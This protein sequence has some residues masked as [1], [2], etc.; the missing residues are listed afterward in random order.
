MHRVSPGGAPFHVLNRAVGQGFLD[1]HAAADMLAWENSGFSIDA[2]VPITLLDR[3]VPNYFQSLEHLLRYCARPLFA[4]ERLSVIRD[5]DGRIARIRY[6]LPRHWITIW[7]VNWVGP[8]RSRKSTQP[9][10][11][12]VIEL[13]PF[14]F[15]DRLADLI[16]QPRRHRHRPAGGWRG[17]RAKPRLWLRP[18]EAAGAM[19]GPA[20]VKQARSVCPEPPAAAGRHGARRW[21]DREAVRCRAVA[22]SPSG[23]GSG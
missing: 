10:A 16:P 23:R 15:L 11:S 21:Q 5:A 18:A 13:A 12:G 7:A 3:D 22:P 4:L 2:S 6:V 17:G 14:E 20:A 19:D 9:G 1:A 8:G